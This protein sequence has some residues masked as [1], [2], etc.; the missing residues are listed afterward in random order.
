MLE[1]ESFVLFFQVSEHVLKLCTLKHESYLQKQSP[2]S[3]CR[4]SWSPSWRRGRVQAQQ[5]LTEKVTAPANTRGVQEEVWGMLKRN[6]SL[7]WNRTLRC[8]YFI[9]PPNEMMANICLMLSRWRRWAK[10]FVLIQ[11][12]QQLYK[13]GATLGSF[14]QVRKLRHGDA[15]C[16]TQVTQLVGSRSRIPNPGFPTQSGSRA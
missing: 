11:S 7:N 13:G 3:C 8:F 2:R 15:D 10:N 6:W 4:C 1:I 5:G 14:P 16:I 12:P 9:N